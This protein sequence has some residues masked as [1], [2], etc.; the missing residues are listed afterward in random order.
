MYSKSTKLDFNKTI[1]LQLKEHSYLQSFVEY[2][3][4]NNKDNTQA[5]TK[6][7]CA[8]NFLS[9][10]ILHVTTKTTTMFT[11]SSSLCLPPV[12]QVLMLHRASMS[13]ISAELSQVTYR[14]TPLHSS[15]WLDWAWA[16]VKLY[17]AL[18]GKFPLTIW[19]YHF[20][21]SVLEECVHTTV[22]C[23]PEQNTVLRTGS[24]S[25][26]FCKPHCTN[27]YGSEVFL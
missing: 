13:V 27:T 12:F 18:R 15:S 2:K 11:L 4:Q 25:W 26:E 3:Q 22:S 24:G 14:H 8:R 1:N 9:D 5:M 21:W 23:L 19:W 6:V 20:R 17:S 7:A 16:E 10:H